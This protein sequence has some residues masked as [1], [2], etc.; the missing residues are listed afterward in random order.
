MSEPEFNRRRD[1]LT[2]RLKEQIKNYN[3][4]LLKQ[5]VNIVIFVLVILP[6]IL[7]SV[8]YLF[9]YIIDHAVNVTHVDRAI[10]IKDF[11]LLFITANKYFHLV[12]FLVVVAFILLMVN[13]HYFVSINFTADELSFAGFIIAKT[14]KNMV[15]QYQNLHKEVE[16]RKL[17]YKQFDKVTNALAALRHTHVEEKGTIEQKV[18]IRDSDW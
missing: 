18:I 11:I 12:I 8:F 4:N 15:L 6:L 17:T 3:I 5:N 13:Y 10:Q 7:G 14:N 2:Q 1:L 9:A 16:F